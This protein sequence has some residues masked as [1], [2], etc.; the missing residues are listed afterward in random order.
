M[1]VIPTQ[2]VIM[3]LLALAGCTTP[4]P[5]QPIAPERP[6]QFMIAP[7]VMTSSNPYVL[8]EVS[9]CLQP[10]PK[11]MAVR[12]TPPPAEPAT[13]I[14]EA[15]TSLPQSL[16]QHSTEVAVDNALSAQIIPEPIIITLP[17]IKHDFTYSPP[18]L[19]VPEAVS[20]ISTKV[21]PWHYVLGF[22]SNQTDLG[23]IEQGL[24]K[25]VLTYLKQTSAT[26]RANMRL[27]IQ[28]RTDDT[29]NS[30]FNQQLA[31]GRANSVKHYLQQQWA[32]LN[33]QNAR[34]ELPRFEIDARGNCCY[35]SDNTT[36]IGRQQNRRVEVLILSWPKVTSPKDQPRDQPRQAITPY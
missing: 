32:S 6:K 30:T 16:P 36:V 15:V 4:P 5:P 18:I 33:L 24:L 9:Q 27:V 31:Q 29:G 25:Q 17:V 35:V 3:G 22:A 26:Q 23:D 34:G 8:C 2:V 21:K 7:Q 12:G 19:S 13:A 14:N 11:V 28:A 1:R 10:T 20:T